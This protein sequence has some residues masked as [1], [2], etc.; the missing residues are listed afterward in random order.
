MR[1]R[2]YIA[3]VAALAAPVAVFLALAGMFWETVLATGAGRL[4]LSVAAT[5]TP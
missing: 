5:M 2:H 4:L 3:A 1:L